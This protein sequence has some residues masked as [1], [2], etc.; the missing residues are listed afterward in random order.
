MRLFKRLV[1][2][3]VVAA[4]A[5][6][7]TGLTAFADVP[8]DETEPECVIGG[9]VSPKIYDTDGNE[10]VQNFVPDTIEAPEADASS[11]YYNLVE[12]GRVTSVKDQGALGTCWAHSA[13][14]SM[15]SNLITKGY[16]NKT[17]DLSEGHLAWFTNGAGNNNAKDPLCGDTGMYSDPKKAYAQGSNDWIAAGTLGSWTGAQLESKFPYSQ[18]ENYKTPAESTRYDSCAHLQNMNIYAPTDKAGI[19]NA[20]VKYGAMS[21]GYYAEGEGSN[22]YNKSTAAYF[23]DVVNNANHAVTVVG[24]DDNYSRNNF[25]AS[26][27]PRSNGAWIIKN[28]WGTSY[29]KNGYFYLSYEEPSIDMVASYDVEKNNNYNHIYQH[30]GML[31][32]AFG[33]TSPFTAANV[34]TAVDTSA[35]SAVGFYTLEAGT[36]YKI[37]VIRGITTAPN[38][39]TVVTSQTAKMTYA[40]YHTVKLSK[41]VQLKKG[42]KFAIALTTMTKSS[43]NCYWVCVDK[44]APTTGASFDTDDTTLTSSSSWYDLS[45]GETRNYCI[46]AYTKASAAAAPTNVKAVAGN[47]QVTLSWSAVSGASNYSVLMKKGTEWLT[48]AS[49]GTKTTYTATGL[50][51][52]GKYYFAVK[53]CVGGSWSASSE[54]V[55]ASPLGNIVPQNV[56]AVA[57]DGKVTI[58]WSAVKGASN[59]AVFLK[60]GTS[61]L[62]VGSAGT[63][64]SFTSRGLAN[65]GKYYYMVRS[66]VNGTW[67]NPSA[68]VF[69]IP[70]RITPQNVKAFAGDGKV[71][72]TWD[73]VKGASNYVVFMKK[74]NTSFNLGSAGTA[75]TFTSKGLTNGSKY[76][77]TVKAY[78]NGSWSDDSAIVSATPVCTTPQNVKAV[79]GAGKATVTW[80]AVK[81]ASN[82]VVMMKK[83]TLWISL[84]SAGTKTS[85]TATGLASGGKY[86]FAVKAYVNG[87]WSDLSDAAPASIS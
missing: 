44:N 70:T 77:Y 62:N 87:A 49:T 43:D 76:Y 41:P 60:K 36:T 39:G 2:A 81:G 15:E 67:S 86:Y 32:N 26:C 31:D 27:R 14:A 28:S 64:T 30:D 69:G 47:G 7:S 23:S 78:V 48:L 38:T 53:A 73:A 57:G 55:S 22:Y 74:G 10:I 33:R 72:L 5:L 75:T 16:A 45:A 18:A 9:Y 4:I 50:A 21:I 34:F 29:G 82:Y 42:E 66:Y 17:I 61:W 12:L 65:G 25:N 59:Y 56:K 6:A 85:Y 24:W 20:L 19:K 1:S 79:G 37:S 13:L 35:V 68:V 46:K 3:A 71:T 51:N 83:G 84:G 80:S 54:I 40:G 58:T 52:G 8:Q 63:S 11:S